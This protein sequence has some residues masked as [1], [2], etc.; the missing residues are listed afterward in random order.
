MTRVRLKVQYLFNARATAVKN[1]SPIKKWA[2][3]VS[4]GWWIGIAGR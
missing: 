3:N 4:N 2:H 1:A